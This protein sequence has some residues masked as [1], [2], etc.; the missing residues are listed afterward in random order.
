MTPIANDHVKDIHSSHLGEALT[1][2]CFGSLSDDQRDTV[3]QHLMSCAICW[4]EFQ[5]LDAAVRVLRFDARVWPAFSIQAV[6]SVLG[7][8]SDLQRS[9]GGHTRFVFVIALLYG[10]EWA[11]GLWS[12]LGYAYDRFGTLLWVLSLPV[13][14]VVGG[15][16]LLA[17]WLDVRSTRAGHTTGLVRSMAALA[18]ILSLLTVALMIVLPAER[19][20]QASFQT[21]TAAAGY[22]KDAELIFLPLLVFVVPTFDAILRFQ[23]EIRSNRHAQ[24]LSLMARAPDAVTPRGM[25]Y[26]SPRLLGVV[27]LIYGVVKVL[28]TNHMLDALTPGPYANFFSVAAYIS[29]GLWFAIA[30]TSLVWYAGALNELK[31]EAV[32]YIALTRRAA[33]PT[34]H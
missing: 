22:L 13:T 28:G 23:R 11:A 26:L 7:V 1:S 27:L 16:V 30:I 24:V 10:V 8:S 18:L 21:R 29:T 4:A 12:E 17:L 9:F 32:A 15:T 25:L 34:K 20:I 14:I 5:R 33:D 6:T 3:E 19:T 2:Y 31:R